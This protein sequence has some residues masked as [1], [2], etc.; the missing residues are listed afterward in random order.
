MK[1]FEYANPTS[2]KDAIGLLGS[3]WSDANILAGGTDQISL[4]KDEIH[5]P[6]R[7]VNIKNIKELG[8]IKK[9][10]SN[11]RIGATVTLDELASNSTVRSEFPSLVTA[12]RGV[13][14]PQIMNMGTVGGDLCQRPRCWYFRNGFGLLGMC[15]LVYTLFSWS[16]GNVLPGWTSLAALVLILG[17]VQLLVLGIFGEYLGRMYMETKRRP[18]YVVGE[19][20]SGGETVERRVA[21]DRRQR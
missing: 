12:A 7:V 2:L 9:A 19:V 17:S 5:S 6:K 4:M 20:V 15:T 21:H 11:L 18:L 1:A 14:S 8:G 3:S 13:G 16:I 10:G